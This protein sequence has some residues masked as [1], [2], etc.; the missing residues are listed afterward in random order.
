MQ[1]SGNSKKFENNQVVKTW[2]KLPH[3]IKKYTKFAYF[4]WLYF[5]H[6]TTF[7]DATSVC[8]FTNF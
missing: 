6:C 7:R 5:S 4:A 2:L 3:K 1:Y 8:D